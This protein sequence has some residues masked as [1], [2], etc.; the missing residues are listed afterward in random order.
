MA[1]DNRALAR[2]SSEPAFEDKK[3]AFEEKRLSSAGLNN[4]YSL[5]RRAEAIGK[6]LTTV[7]LVE[8]LLDPLLVVAMLYL[9]AM[10]VGVNPGTQFWVLATVAFLVSY[11]VFKEANLCRFWRHGGVRAQTQQVILAW[12]LVLGVMLA[13]GYLTK[14]GQWFSRPMIVLWAVLTPPILLSGHAMVRRLIYQFNKSEQFARTAVIVGINQLSQQLAREMGVDGRLNVRF[15]GF[16][17]DRNATRGAEFDQKTLIGPLKSLPAYVKRN[18]I[19]VIYVALPMTQQK[20]IMELLDGLRDTTASIYFVPELFMFDLIQ[21][22]VDDVNG[23]PVVAV[24]ETPFFG[25]NG[26]L[27]RLSDLVI[28]SIALV[29]LSPL[30]L[31]IALAVKATSAGPVIFRQRRYGL[32]GEEIVVYKF[33]SMT[34][35]EDGDNVCQAKTNDRRVTRVGQYLRRYSLD[36][37]PQFINVLQ[38]RMSVVGPRPHAVSHNEMYRGLIKGYMVRHKVRPGITGWAQIHGLRGETETVEKMK[39]RIDYDLD[40]LRS[41]SLWLDVK[42][43]FKTAVVVFKDKNAY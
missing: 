24:C 14:T 27:K 37:L 19:N 4:V 36:E 21:A 6:P 22:R 31:G 39:S 16:F 3:P 28:A 13:I 40:Y 26:V 2:Q 33:R 34:V 9:S 15:T 10:V 12:L 17:D 18:G 32:G 1:V 11:I 23:I 35:C 7:R 41:W 30:M 20:R 8:L 42:I 43:I 38:G 25:V 5:Q 29:L